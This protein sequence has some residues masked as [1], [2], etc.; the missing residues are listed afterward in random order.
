MNPKENTDWLKKEVENWGKKEIINDYQAQ[1]ILSLY[2][3]AKSP[4]EPATKEDKQSS[5][6][7][8]VSVLGSLLVG[9]GVILFV[10]IIWN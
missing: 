3:L 7:T 9:M 10:S 8:V 5:S 2:G 4:A 6:I 1:A